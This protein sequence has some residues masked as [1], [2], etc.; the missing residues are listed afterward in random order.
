M[1][2]HIQRNPGVNILNTKVQELLIVAGILTETIID[3]NY[4]QL[5]WRLFIIRVLNNHWDLLF[6]MGNYI[7]QNPR[8][9]I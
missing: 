5:Y 1:G 8:G 2:N 3:A 6:G 9:Q 4:K 7:Q